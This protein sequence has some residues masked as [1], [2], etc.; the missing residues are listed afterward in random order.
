MNA[1]RTARR[2]I[3][4]TAP[5]VLAL[6]DAF[7]QYESELL[8]T[9]YYMVGNI[10]DARDALQETFLKC[11]RNQEKLPEIRQLKAWI[12]RIALNTARDLRQTAWRRKRNDLP[13]EELVPTKSDERPEVLLSKREEM[14]QLREAISQLRDEEKE[15][16]LLRENGQMTYEEIGESLGIPTGTVKTRMRL[17]VTKLRSVVAPTNSP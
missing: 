17:A 8:G 4:D 1:T 13:N 7:A 15:V 10:D 11:W 6:E 14:N 12:F 16:F 5:D 9:L 2:D 3:A